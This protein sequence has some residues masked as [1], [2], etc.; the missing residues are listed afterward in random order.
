MGEEEGRSSHHIS[1]S[2]QASFR[3]RM[4]LDGG[5]WCLE[6]LRNDFPCGPVVKLPALAGAMGSI[7][8]PGRPHVLQRS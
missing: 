2:A 8:G 6:A 5:R 4:R 1:K 3:A 7:P